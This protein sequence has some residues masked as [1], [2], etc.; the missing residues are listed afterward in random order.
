M[1]YY[2]HNWKT[3]PFH[4]FASIRTS[5]QNCLPSSN[6][7]STKS[8]AS[9]SEHGRVRQFDQKLFQ[10]ASRAKHKTKAPV[11]FLIRNFAGATTDSVRT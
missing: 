8:L 6:G 7:C 4:L 1:S 11:A 2:T 5:I 10:A 3:I 9:D